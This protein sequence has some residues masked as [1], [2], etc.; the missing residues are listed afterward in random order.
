L[1]S[2]SFGRVGATSNGVNYKSNASIMKAKH[3]I[4]L[5]ALG[6]CFDFA[7]A[8]SKIT[9]AYYA[10]NLLLIAVCLKV[11]GVILLAFKIINYEG[12]KKFMNS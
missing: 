10:N 9:H 7:G 4:I 11:A 6:Y 8:W 3:A 1:L 2:L 12:F 5:I